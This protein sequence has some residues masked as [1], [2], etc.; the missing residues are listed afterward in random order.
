MMM[1]SRDVTALLGVISL[2]A[3]ALL[4]PAPA[5]TTTSIHR[6]RP[7]P[8]PPATALGNMFRGYQDED[9]GYGGFGGEAR[10]RSAR[11]GASSPNWRKNQGYNL[12]RPTPLE[13]GGSYNSIRDAETNPYY[14]PGWAQSVRRDNP[15]SRSRYEDPMGADPMGYGPDT[16]PGMTN[17]RRTEKW[18]SN[19]T[20][21]Y[22]DPVWSQSYA[23][24]EDPIREWDHT[25]YYAPGYDR[26]YYGRGGMMGGMDGGYY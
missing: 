8:R 21:P 13:L 14:D 2:S 19:P 17:P 6:P 20:H 9:Y 26:N 10:V 22:Y 12:S 24:R 11:S 1:L 7:N 23:R 5:P 18:Y 25:S 15:S 16:Y 4:A 3:S